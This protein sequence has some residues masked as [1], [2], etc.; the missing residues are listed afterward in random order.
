M[1]SISDLQ[2]LGAFL[3]GPGIAAFLT[4]RFL[5]A[6]GIWSER[7]AI[8][9]LV[10]E[11]TGSTA[12]LGLAAL[13]KLGPAIAL[14]PVGGVL[15]DR[16]GSI[17]LLR[18]T[19]AVNAALALALAIFAMALPL[20]AVLTLTAALGCVQAIAAAPIKSAV[21]QIVR[22]ED[23]SV[24]YPLSSA[25]FNLA[26]FIGPAAAGIAI[27]TLGLWAAFMVSVTGAVVFLVVLA[28]WKDNDRRAE[29]SRSHWIREIGEAA[30]FVARDR[31]ISPVF[32]LH[33]A[34]SF[35]LRPFIDLLPAHVARLDA[36]G[37]AMLGFA[38][39]AF[40]FG[41]VS[42]AVWMA[43][44]ALDEA[45]ARR[46]LFGTL[47]AIACLLFIA[48]RD[49]TLPFLIAA[50]AFGAAMMVR[51][52]ATLTLIQLESPEGMRGRVSGLYSTVIRGGAALGAALIG[53]MGAQLGLPLAT[54]G[55][56]ML[57]TIALAAGWRRLRTLDPRTGA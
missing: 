30:A 11:R 55:A 8:G 45:L 49:D 46:L 15:A 35:C 44:A 12:L 25:T 53:V 1:S 22:R 39:S 16:F 56:A 48:W 21:P 27:A 36:D 23:L 31:F 24:A 40:G 5:A 10:W 38:T 2:R 13:L 20:W 33:V 34:A 54:T 6:M 41:A 17:G 19:Y 57:C 43:A 26:A 32:L 3:R 29:P 28:R 37:P 42:G 51:S 50:A 7:I 9:W 4:G 47:G 14:G 18:Q 52:T